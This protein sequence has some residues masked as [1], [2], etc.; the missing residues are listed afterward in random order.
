MIYER[1][2]NSVLQLLSCLFSQMELC[3]F[4]ES[5]ILQ[6]I[7]KGTNVNGFLCFRSINNS[8]VVIPTQLT[9]SVTVEREP[10]KKPGVLQLWEK[11][12]S[13]KKE[14]KVKRDDNFDAIPCQLLRKYIQYARKYVHPKLSTDACKILQVCCLMFSSRG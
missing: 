11:E 1:T 6:Q 10:D 7:L 9:Q 12:N 5:R 13:L 14:L 3:L 2:Q 8:S 4:L